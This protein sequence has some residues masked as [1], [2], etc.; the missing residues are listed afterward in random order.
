MV[1]YLYTKYPG[2]IVDKVECIYKKSL[3][4]PDWL[5]KYRDFTKILILR[6]NRKKAL[7]SNYNYFM[8]GVSLNTYVNQPNNSNETNNIFEQID[9]DRWIK[10]W[11]PANPDV[12][13][14]EELMLDPLFP[15]LNKNQSTPTP[16]RLLK[17]D[18]SYL[19]RNHNIDAHTRADIACDFSSL[20]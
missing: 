13:Y 3:P 18:L 14:L 11:A 19:A 15:R 9:Y 5:H 2:C 4:N 20:Q 6:K 8:P 12:Y 7:L 1:E 16:A 17:L 10:H